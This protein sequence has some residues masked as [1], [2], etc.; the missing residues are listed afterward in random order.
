MEVAAQ[1]QSYSFYHTSGA[2]Y[3]TVE[4][5]ESR[6]TD[7]NHQFISYFNTIKR[8][9]KLGLKFVNSNSDEILELLKN[10]VL[11]FS[12]NHVEIPRDN[13]S[14]SSTKFIFDKAEICAI[15]AAK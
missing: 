6:I 11:I 15:L 5:L 3:C 2:I 14:N 8:G 1:V 13:F 12:V 4:V 7:R 10:R 9:Q